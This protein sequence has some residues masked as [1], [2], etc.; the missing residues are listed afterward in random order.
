MSKCPYPTFSASTWSD[1]R[2]GDV[3]GGAAAT[4]MAAV[5]AEGQIDSSSVSMPTDEVICEEYTEGI[6]DN[7]VDVTST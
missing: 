1:G 7:F 4:A 5:A 3:V 6:F 2:V